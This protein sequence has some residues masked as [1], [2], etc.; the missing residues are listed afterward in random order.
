MIVG[1]VASG[2]AGLCIKSALTSKSFVISRNQIAWE[3]QSLQDQGPKCQCIKNTENKKTWSIEA[4]GCK[5]L[6]RPCLHHVCH[7]PIDKSKSH[8]QC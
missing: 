4:P 6:P 1:G 7:D 2:L 5:L 3:G 8:D